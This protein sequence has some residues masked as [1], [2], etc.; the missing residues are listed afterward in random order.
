MSA[1]IRD[2]LANYAERD[3]LRL[4]MPGH[5][6]EGD[7]ERLDLTEVDGADSLYEANGII[8]RSEDNAGKLFGAKTFYSTEGS[9]L[10][11]RAMT[12]LVAVYSASR[13]K[14][15]RILAAP[16]A[17]KSFISA[18]AVQ[19]IDV[20]W[21]P[22]A[23]GDSYLRSSADPSVV[24]RLLSEA[25][26]S[27]DPFTAV[28]ITS[29]DY[30]G[31]IADIGGISSVCRKRGV[32]LAV[33]NA[34][35]AYLKFLPGRRHPMELGADMCCD[36]AHKTLPVLTGGAY[37]HISHGADPILSDNARGALSIFGSTSPSYLILDSLDRANEELCSDL[38]GR[39]EAL[40][41]QLDGIR[42]RLTKRGYILTG[43]E[44]CKL[45]LMP[46]SYGYTGNGLAKILI[47]N[48]IVPEFYD[49]DYLVL[50]PSPAVAHRLGELEQVLLSLPK[51]RAITDT[52]PCLP[53]RIQA[54]SPREALYSPSRLTPVELAAGHTVAALTVGCPPAVPILTLGQ[55]VTEEAL[56]LLCYYGI[57][58]LRVIK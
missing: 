34:H 58:H 30:L 17:H 51:R 24:D 25:E 21:L 1:P 9:S 6:G 26:E 19:D 12:Y 50:M 42:E 10:A 44:P 23:D 56:P 46:K 37:L 48:G 39:L 16:N 43:D 4:H 38:P 22:Y 18:V 2:F 40:A 41:R 54:L 20:A 27:G 8:S 28:Y 13:G 55:R 53:Q 7:I 3:P 36:S 57:S 11:I 33:D 31:H 52:P 35:G 15:P 47:D 32:L 29:P 45:T 49:P 5:K 14:R